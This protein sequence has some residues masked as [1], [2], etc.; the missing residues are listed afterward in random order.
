MT[1][2]SF[3][4]IRKF[5]VFF[6][7]VAPNVAEAKCLMLE[8]DSWVELWSGDV[9]CAAEQGCAALSAVRAYGSGTGACYYVQ[10][11][12]TKTQFAEIA[13]GPG[14]K[15]LSFYVNGSSVG[16]AVLP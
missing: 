3:R 4:C 8:K 13:Q 6:L 16:S 10:A 1:I 5:S 12:L 2:T 9:N 7:L 14:F 11:D 15:T